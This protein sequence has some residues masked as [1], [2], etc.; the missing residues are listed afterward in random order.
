MHPPYAHLEATH[1]A[2]HAPEVTVVRQGGMEPSR[3]P[4]DSP[5]TAPLR[6]AIVAAWGAEPLLV[7]PMGQPA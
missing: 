6:Q 7:P 5:F 2:R 4:L 3:T 1:V